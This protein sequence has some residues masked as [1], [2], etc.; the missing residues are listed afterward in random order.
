M[1]WTIHIENLTNW[2]N[3]R[4]YH[5]EMV[6]NGDDSICHI[7]KTIEIN[8]SSKPSVQAI[9]LLHECGH[10]LIFDNGSKFN[11]KEK[12]EY[13]KNTVAY[14]VFAVIEEVEAWKRGKELAKR[15]DIPIEEAEWEAD[16]VRALKKYINWAS[17]LKEKNDDTIRRGK[18]DKSNEAR[19]ECGDSTESTP[20]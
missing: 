4:G 7:S 15:L 5:V 8:S 11:F 2:A 12:R 17:D 16:M 20:K 19:S 3:D 1:D 18:V 14:K 10:A 6:K 13:S 9:R